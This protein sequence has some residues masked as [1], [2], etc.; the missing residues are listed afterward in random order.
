LFL[1]IFGI[2]IGILGAGFEEVVQEENRDNT[3]ELEATEE[4]PPAELLGSPLERKAFNFVNG[5]GSD[6]AKWFVSTLID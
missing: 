3:E 5:I 6:V 2:P 1:S 4:D